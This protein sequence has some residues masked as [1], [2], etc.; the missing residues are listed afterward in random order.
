MSRRRVHI[1]PAGQWPATRGLKP[2]GSAQKAGG[3]RPQERSAS[4]EIA[5]ASEVRTP[6]SFMLTPSK[7]W[8]IARCWHKG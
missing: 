5:R 3:R 6:S 8:R 1:Q 2:P 4:S 7:R